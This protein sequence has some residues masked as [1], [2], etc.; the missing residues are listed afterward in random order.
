MRIRVTLAAL[1]GLIVLSG[2]GQT[3]V[4]GVDTQLA[5][6]AIVRFVNAVPD[7]SGLDFRFVDGGIEGSPQY[8]NVPFRSFTPYQRVRPG[9]RQMRVFTDPAPYANNIA[10]A[11]QMHVDTTFTFEPNARYTIISYGFSRTGQAPKERLV[12]LRD[13]IPTTLTT[14]QV[15]TRTIHAAP[16]LGNVDVYVR[17]SET[18]A[19]I[20]GAPA[21]A[22]VSPG[23]A[24]SYA[25]VTARPVG[26]LLYRWDVAPAGTTTGI[27]LGTSSG[28]AGVVGTASANPLPGFQV[29]RTAVT[30][31]LL[32][33]TVTGSRAPAAFT[34]AT[35]LFM[36]DKALD[37]TEP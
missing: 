4:S 36:P 34:T 7:T 30:A 25:A 8:A 14:T 33:A 2:C 23:T 15:A 20:A 17:T 12:I 9:T 5:E 37:I 1:T 13:E 6:A 32:P 18:A 26:T 16:G 31:V 35:I 22:N 29:G 24:T 10:V 28:L 19:G 3:D 21:N 27:T 11:T